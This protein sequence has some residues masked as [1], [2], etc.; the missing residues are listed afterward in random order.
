MK[1]SRTGTEREGGE[2]K[3]HFNNH[4]CR[5]LTLLLRAESRAVSVSLRRGRTPGAH[6]Q[7]QKDQKVH[8]PPPG[9]HDARGLGTGRAGRGGGGGGGGEGG[10]RSSGPNAQHDF[11]YTHTREEEGGVGWWLGRGATRMA[12]T[13]QSSSEWT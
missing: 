1:M 3:T 12:I 5:P 6:S 9:S 13:G 4:K 10:E 7:H 2:K 11:T 8:P